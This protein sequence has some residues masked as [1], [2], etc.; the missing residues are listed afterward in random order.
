MWFE[1]FDLLPFVSMCFF[2]LQ[3]TLEFGLE[4][5]H[6]PEVELSLLGSCDELSLLLSCDELSLLL[7][8][9]EHHRSQPFYQ[10][11]CFF[12]Y[13]LMRKCLCLNIYIRLDAC[14]VMYC[15]QV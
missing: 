11:L 13:V 1:M 8:C 7:L 3:E 4:F 10:V 5:Y 9:D 12:F 15:K 14:V 2:L 6:P